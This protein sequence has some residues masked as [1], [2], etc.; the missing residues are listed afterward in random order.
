DDDDDDEGDAPA[1]LKGRKA[2]VET[3][4]AELEAQFEGLHAVIGAWKEGGP[5][6][7]GV[8]LS[9]IQELYTRIQTCVAALARFRDVR[10]AD[11]SRS[12]FLGLL[13]HDV[14]LYYGYSDFLVS[15]FLQMFSPGEMI[16]FLEANES[17]RPVTLRVNSLRA[18]RRDVA[19]SLIDRGVNLDPIKWSDVGLQ[20]FDSSV[21]LGATPEYLAGQYMLQGAASFLPVMALDPQPEEL[22]LDMCSAP[23]GKTTYIAALMKNTGTL[24]AND[25]S[26]ERISSLAANI[27]RLGVKN[28]VITCMDGAAIGDHVK[29][30]DRILLDAPCSGL[31]V[32]SRDPSVKVNRGLA[33]INRCSEMQRKLLNAAVDM[34]KPG[35]IIVYSTCSVAVDENEAV[36][37]AVL[38]Q[39]KGLKILPVDISF[40]SPGFSRYRS[41]RFHHSL[42]HS[43]RFYPHLH[44]TDGFFF[45]KLQYNPPPTPKGLSAPA[46][47]SSVAAA[48]AKKLA[49]KKPAGKKSF[50][51]KRGPSRN[52]LPAGRGSFAKRPSREYSHNKHSPAKKS[53]PSFAAQRRSSNPPPHK[54]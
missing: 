34:V 12:D 21:P 14:G 1:W 7:E 27:H 37:D 42:K 16:E 25:V 9:D 31:G 50:D 11:E 10:H 15:M 51:N 40:G 49:G 24:F 43:R 47:S 22:V 45:V 32:I 41:K 5:E 8:M 6:T 13:G 36:V 23:G 35:G 48:A 26:R 28:C 3:P 18:R 17:A 19:R 33:E 38:R 52:G 30:F 39:R 54:K 20:V 29:R 44:N 2:Q 4:Q 53:K 46:S